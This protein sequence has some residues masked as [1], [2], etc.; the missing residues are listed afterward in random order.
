MGKDEAQILIYREQLET[1]TAVQKPV[2][3][4]TQ[5]GDVYHQLGSIKTSGQSQSVL[6]FY[7]MEVR[8]GRQCIDTGF[9]C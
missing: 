4:S 1:T 8:G 9:H 6:S 2:H 5:I 3:E 7:S